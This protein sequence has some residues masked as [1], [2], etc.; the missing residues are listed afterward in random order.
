MWPRDVVAPVG[1]LGNDAGNSVAPSYHCASR[2]GPRP[3]RFRRDAGD[4]NRTLVLDRT[5]IG[6][7]GA[8][9][10][11]AVSVFVAMTRRCEASTPAMLAY[12]RAYA[13]EIEWLRSN[14]AGGG[15]AFTGRLPRVL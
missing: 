5:R 3:Q 1:R 7:S 15:A 9:R 14:D 11:R 6:A 4:E 12:R 2:R 10:A 13:N 8:P